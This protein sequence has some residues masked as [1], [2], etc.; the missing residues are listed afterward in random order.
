MKTLA[1]ENLCNRFHEID[2]LQHAITYLS[3]DQMVMMPPH[4]SEMRSA[5]IAEL[6]GL[7]HARLTA[8]EV[9]SWL[10]ELED[11]ADDVSV[12]EM[13]RVWSNANCLPEDLVK[14][15]IVV[16]AKCEMG[17]R[18]QRAAND[19]QG[20]LKN[21]K[22]VVELSRSEAKCRQESSGAAT[23]YEAMLGLHCHG[24]SETLINSVF[25]ELRSELPGLLQRILEKQDELQVS[26]IA[27]YP[28]ENQIALNKE[29]LSTLGFNFDS[30]RLDQSM[31]PFSTGS[32]GDSRITTRYETD[33][34]LESLA[35]TAHEVGHASYES[36]LPEEFTGLP[37]GGSRN[38]CVHESQSLLFEKQIFY[39]KAFMHF[40]SKKIHHHLPG[41]ANLSAEDLWKIGT[42]VAPGKIRVEADEVTYP[43]HVMLR[44]EIESALIN[45]EIEADDIPDI[46]NEKMM[47]YL[48]VDTRGDYINGCMQD[49][50]WTDG[51][52]GYFPSYTIGAVNAAQIFAVIKSEHTD[53]QERFR[54]GDVQFVRDWLLKQIWSKGCQLES[55]ELMQSATGTST[56]AESLIEH[57]QARYL[58]FE[59]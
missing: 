45:S 30:G 58:R 44:Y 53:W 38:M 6:A 27:E 25:K 49:I 8:P 33:T 39:S 3:W 21:F 11:A 18:T 36:M 57:L 59:Y 17:W 1:Y 46:W 23:P 5:S 55:Q 12:R 43:L 9:G 10:S 14:E 42:R 7:S 37:V 54:Q 31:H 32:A 2:K 19:W 35:G 51:A 34:F 41:A 56:Q 40:L 22:P 4:G 29:M 52:F 20:F 28:I 15:Q 47:S 13:K 24:D 26:E 16:G 48:G 50:H